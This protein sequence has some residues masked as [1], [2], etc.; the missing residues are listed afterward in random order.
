M[1][2]VDMMGRVIVEGDATDRI[3]TSEMTP[4]VYVLRLI[5]CEKV[6]TQKIVIE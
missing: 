1:Q 2:I 3:S 4:G 5:N 6:Q